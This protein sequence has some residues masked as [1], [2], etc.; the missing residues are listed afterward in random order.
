MGGVGK[1]GL[2]CVTMEKNGGVIIDKSLL[3]QTLLFSVM[4]H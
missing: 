4:M 3:A 1:L 2:C